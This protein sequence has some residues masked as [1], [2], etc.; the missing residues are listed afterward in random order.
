MP[1]ETVL[2]T[3]K[4]R[5]AYVTLN[6]PE[7]LNA[8]SLQMRK[9]LSDVLARVQ[10]SDARVLILLGAG[11]RAFSTGAD[12]K[13]FQQPKALVEERRERLLFDPWA[14]LD[15]LTIPTIAALHGFALGGG[16]ELAL[17]CDLRIAAEDTVLGFPETGIGILPGAGGTQRLPR[18]IGP[19]QALEL[20]F[21]GRHI[22]ATEA[23]Q[24]GLVNRIVPVDQLHDT[25]QDIATTIRE[26]APLALRFAK[27]AV[28][29]GL[30]GPLEAGLQLE[31]DLLLFLYT[32]EDRAEGTRA[33]T[34]KR[35]PNFVG[36]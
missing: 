25:V 12:I 5:T 20:I 2:Y 24:L 19:S 33:F 16:A 36:R 26:R 23:L 10:T 6:R 29:R 9:D 22:G 31:I 27:E 17:V 34:E 35:R 32:T 13:E 7:A 3:M 1:Y 14:E 21:T 30:Q 28:K 8:I 4:D 15:R 18:L 11:D